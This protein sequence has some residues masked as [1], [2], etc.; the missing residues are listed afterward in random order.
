MITLAISHMIFI[1][2]RP[3]T[4]IIHMRSCS[5]LCWFGKC[6]MEYTESLSSIKLTIDW[7]TFNLHLNW[8]PSLSTLICPFKNIKLMQRMLNIIPWYVWIWLNSVWAVLSSSIIS[9]FLTRNRKVNNAICIDQKQL[10]QFFVWDKNSQT[11]F[12]IRQT[13]EISLFV[14]SYLGECFQPRFFRFHFQV[15]WLAFESFWVS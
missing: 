10:F 5:N 7:K 4:P 12:Y 9:I 2:T 15:N 8:M 3:F 14:S 1:T 13:F 6:W 11:E